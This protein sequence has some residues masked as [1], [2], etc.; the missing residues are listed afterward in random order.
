MQIGDEM[1]DTE[2]PNL[3][4]SVQREWDGQVYSEVRYDTDIRTKQRGIVIDRANRQFS[5]EV[6]MQRA[7]HLAD[8]LGLEYKEDLE[9]HCQAMRKIKCH[10]PDCIAKG[11]S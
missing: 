11:R 4:V 10:C 2:K 1:T 5:N 9:W 3:I 7:K 8:L 6:I